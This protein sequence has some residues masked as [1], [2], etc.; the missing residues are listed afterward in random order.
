MLYCGEV[1]VCIMNASLNNPGSTGT[2][3]QRMWIIDACDSAARSLWVEWVAETV[4]SKPAAAVGI[5]ADPAGE[6]LVESGWRE[7][8]EVI[9][10]V[11]PEGGF[12]PAELAAAAGWPRAAIGSY[13]LR[14]ETAAVALAARLV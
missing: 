7:A 5:V 2:R 11:G 12:A 10:L 13:V 1:D 8:A 9:G 6:P 3:P 14:I 4:A